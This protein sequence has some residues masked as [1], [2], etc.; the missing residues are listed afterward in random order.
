MDWHVVVGAVAGVLSVAAIIP[1]LRDIL[2]KNT[3][4]NLVSW[5]L[6]TVAVLI[7]LAGQISAGASW[8]ALLLIGATIENLAV[9]VL[10]LR[11]YG[12]TK[13]GRVEQVTL[14][15]CVLA[16]VLWQVT[17]NPLIAIA[18]AIAADSVAYVPTV[19]KAYRDPKSELAFFWGSLVVVDILAAV[20]STKIDFANLG[21]PI[22]YAILNGTVATVV[23]LRRRTQ[24]A[25]L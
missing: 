21:F 24:I 23:F 18:F 17:E 13:F 20:S 12:Y 2:R 22:S 8:S 25:S 4:P 9:I 1:Y 3:R 5:S 11:G 10:A 14:L 16:I 7:T 15:L 19:T 6:W